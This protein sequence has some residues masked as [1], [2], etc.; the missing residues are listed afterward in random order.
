VDSGSVRLAERAD[1]EGDRA[2]YPAGSRKAGSQVDEVASVRTSS[3]CC[4]GS[5]LGSV[6]NT[7]GAGGQGGAAECAAQSATAPSGCHP[8]R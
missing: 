7:A 4:H 6:V 2:R 3:S 8:V 5:Y 1:G